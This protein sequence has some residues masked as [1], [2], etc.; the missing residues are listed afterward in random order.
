MDS[1]KTTDI[2]DIDSAFELGSNDD[3]K[4]PKD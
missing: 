2:L 1:L 4:S 3:A